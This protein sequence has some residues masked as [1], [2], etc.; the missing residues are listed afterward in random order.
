M[1]DFEVLSHPRVTVASV[2]RAEVAVVDVAV[3][4]L[5]Y[6]QR[7]PLGGVWDVVEEDEKAEHGTRH[8]VVPFHCRAVRARCR[9][10]R[11]PPHRWLQ[12]RRPHKL[13]TKRVEVRRDGAC[14]ALMGEHRLKQL[15]RAI[16]LC[17]DHDRVGRV[18]RGLC[19]AVQTLHYM[20]LQRIHVEAL[21]AVDCGESITK[22][23]CVQAV[24]PLV[25]TEPTVHGSRWWVPRREVEFHVR[26]RDLVARLCRLVVIRLRCSRVR[27]HGRGLA[28]AGKVRLKQAAHLK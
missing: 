5:G 17:D 3:A 18:K 19:G 9:T 7:A 27:R 25:V 10:R 1:D 28:E 20:A 4:A 13:N 8:V 2:T 11:V 14:K 16:H 15:H 24:R 23:A 22:Q 26:A 6:I 12:I 21:E